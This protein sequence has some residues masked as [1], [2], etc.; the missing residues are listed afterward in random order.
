M[1]F[2]ESKTTK[3]MTSREIAELTEKQHSHVMRDITTM[4][5]ALEKDVSTFGG[6][7][8]DA[9]KREQPMFRLPYD[10]TICL[11]T[12][13]DVK[14]RMKVIK[15]WQE[16]E[17]PTVS[18]VT[19]L[20]PMTIAQKYEQL[21]VAR[22]IMADESL[23]NMFPLVWQQVSDGVQNDIVAMFG[24]KSLLGHTQQVPLD[25]VEIAKQAGI[26]IPQNRKGAI[27]KAI[28]AQSS[29]PAIQVQRVINGS[30]RQANAYTNHDEILGLIRKLA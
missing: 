8:L 10:E 2:L 5:E 26:T 7:F 14:A 29:M 6:I 16:L 23:K 15:R 30:I 18:P 4:L 27:G 1:Q 24:G 22:E 9:Y 12:G 19:T 20:P 17:Q 28:K 13:Y 21:N 11:L 25:V 3:T